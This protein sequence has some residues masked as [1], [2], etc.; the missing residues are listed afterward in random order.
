MGNVVTKTDYDHYINKL[1]LEIRDKESLS[2]IQSPNY[3][4]LI[5]E[6]D[7]FFKSQKYDQSIDCLTK[8]F[9]V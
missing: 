4:K 5:K 1:R 2:S 3:K 7:N 6:A 9:V 8:A